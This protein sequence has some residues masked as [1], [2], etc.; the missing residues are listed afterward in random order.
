MPA[1][2]YCI[3][4]DIG[5][6]KMLAGLVTRAGKIAH[7]QKRLT[8]TAPA[9]ILAAARALCEGLRAE[10]PVPLRGLGL[11]SAGMIDTRTKRVIH[12][13][14]N[15]PGWAGT[16]LRQLAL[17]GLPLVVENDARALA[18]GEATLGAGLGYESLLAVTVGTGIGGAIILDG[19]VWHGAH[20]SAGEIGYLVVGWQGG[21]PLCLDQYASGPAIERA[22][23]K[24]RGDETRP[25]LPEIHR[26]ALMGEA[27]AATAIEQ[28]AREL[29]AILAG[30]AAAINPQ[31]LVIGGGVPQIGPLWWQAFVAAFRGAAPPPLQATPLLPAAL[32]SEAVMLGAAM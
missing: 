15:L 21:A 29:G 1:P 6:S 17:A 7:V 3:G 5:A 9:A 24:L 13:N 16:D 11:G 28:K 19:E 12:A 26:R 27:L 25:P 4:L 2:A 22:Y 14:D 31:A 20:G 23:Q 18:Y 10:A 8:P 32:G 30:V